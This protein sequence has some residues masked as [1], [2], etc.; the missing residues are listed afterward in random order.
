[1]R[2]AQ[3]TSVA[4]FALPSDVEDMAWNPFSPFK[5][6]ASCEDGSVVCYDYRVNSKPLFTMKCHE[7]AVSGVSFAC[8]ALYVCAHA[9]T[10]LTLARYAAAPWL[11][12]CSRLAPWT[13]L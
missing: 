4:K 10:L 13:S 1:M 8:V 3:P 9:V 11:K 5:F 12:A 2:H 6:V 7:K